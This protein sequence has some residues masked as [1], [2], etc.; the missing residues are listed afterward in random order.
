MTKPEITD[1]DYR[2]FVEWPAKL[3]TVLGVP[4]WQQKWY[5]GAA[6]EA[7]YTPVR[8]TFSAWLDAV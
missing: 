8:S 6:H 4:F 2:I 7:C 5:S 1:E 3:F